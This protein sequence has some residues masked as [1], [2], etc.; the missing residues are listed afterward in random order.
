[1]RINERQ[2]DQENAREGAMKP[3]N[4]VSI[5]D[6]KS[7][8]AMNFKGLSFCFSDVHS[9]EKK[10]FQ[11]FPLLLRSAMRLISTDRKRQQFNIAHSD[12]S[13]ARSLVNRPQEDR[14]MR[15]KANEDN[16]SHRKLQKHVIVLNSKR[17][18]IHLIEHQ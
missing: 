15:R 13:D 17:C 3:S 10:L 14:R 8:L 11:K 18:H 6:K 16:H 2:R 5:C 12:E 7:C 9:S 1:M 4:V